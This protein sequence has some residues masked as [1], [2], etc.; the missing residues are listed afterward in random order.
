MKQLEFEDLAAW[1]AACQARGLDS[2]V[3]RW[4]SEVR[5][6]RHDGGVTVGPVRQATLLAY[7][8]GLLLRTVIDAPPEDLRR[9]LDGAGLR[10]R[11]VLDH[12]G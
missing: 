2:A 6:I 12:I 5:A 1:I 10:L 7:D 3:L 9:Q 4:I 11:V 8:G